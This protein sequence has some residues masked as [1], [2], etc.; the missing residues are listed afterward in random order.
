MLRRPVCP[1][2]EVMPIIATLAEGTDHDESSLPISCGGLQYAFGRPANGASSHVC[3]ELPQ[4]LAFASELAFGPQQYGMPWRG[5][6]RFGREVECMDQ[7]QRSARP[8]REACRR[9][10]GLNGHFGKIGSANDRHRASSSQRK[11]A[12]LASDLIQ[13]P[14]QPWVS[15]EFSTSRARIGAAA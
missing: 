15:H 2:A 13:G 9:R 12:S 8:H 3:A 7:V 5:L 14:C 4:S 10:S 1:A 6:Q 11:R